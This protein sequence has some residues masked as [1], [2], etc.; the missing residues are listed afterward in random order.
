MEHM[1]HV[2]EFYNIY[3]N[4]AE[5]SIDAIICADVHGN[6]IFWN[7]AAE[8]MFGYSRGDAI[9]KPLTILMPASY[10][11]RHLAG[12]KRFLETGKPTATGKVHE[13]EGLKKDGEVFPVQLSVSATKENV[14]IFTGIVRDITEHRRADDALKKYAVQLEQSNRLKD[15]FTD[16]IRH[17][18]ANPV[19][20]IK[21]F[22]ELLIDE[23]N[24]KQKEIALRIRNNAN[25]IMEMIET[26]SNYAKLESIE[27]LEMKKLDL[28]NI[29]RGVIENFRPLLEEKKM[30][31]EY[32]CKEPCYAAANPVIENVFSN[33]LS[34]A[35]KYSPESKKIEVN[36]LN[37]DNS[38]KIYTKDWGYGIADKDKIELFTRFKRVDK[39]GVKGTGL[40][41]AIVKRIVELHKGRVWIEDNP[42]GGSIFYVEIPKG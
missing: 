31:L 8:K 13:V 2:L 19:G 32:L 25:A 26:A 34:N 37:E 17:D 6:I 40:G 30:K 28:D 7:K 18:L 39:K 29:F 14:W 35:I 36:I 20:I 38:C 3:K 11:E 16:I 22:A 12:M 15:L 24:E 1:E 21:S 9:G 5:S 27:K 41:L 4:I 10:R 23:A 33:L 42:E